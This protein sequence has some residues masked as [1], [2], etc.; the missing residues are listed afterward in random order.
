MEGSTF[1]TD[2][3]DITFEE[4]CQ[5]ISSEIDNNSMDSNPRENVPPR[6]TMSK[7][8][9]L[10][11]QF[12]QPD[13]GQTE[14][15]I[16]CFDEYRKAAMKAIK[17]HLN[18]FSKKQKNYEILD[19]SI[20]KVCTR[21]S[22]L[23]LRALPIWDY[24][25][26]LKRATTDEVRNHL[27]QQKHKTDQIDKNRIFQKRWLTN[28]PRLLP[29]EAAVM[30]ILPCLI[31]CYTITVPENR[32]DPF[33]TNVQN[34]CTGWCNIFV[35][36]LD[37]PFQTNMPDPSSR[38]KSIRSLCDRFLTIDRRKN[39]PR[40]GRGS[41]KN[42]RDIQHRYASFWE[43]YRRFAAFCLA[44]KDEPD[45]NITLS[46]AL[47]WDIQKRN[48]SGENFVLNHNTLSQTGTINDVSS[49]YTKEDIVADTG[50][51]KILKLFDGEDDPDR[52]T[53]HEIAYYLNLAD[54]EDARSKEYNAILKEIDLYEC[55]D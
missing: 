28:I 53:L 6:G 47:F 39:T 2:C 33:D 36:L 31:T 51:D 35:E 12:D 22:D 4:L 34:A 5:L 26:L 23:L 8:L 27:L 29:H 45:V 11:Q 7:L 10:L 14:Q 54:I 37:T 16:I 48:M 52:L 15:D 25:T 41:D 18:A 38:A 24:D 40:K 44:C 46:T 50:R 32:L 13:R 20:Q 19:S 43:Y 3:E 21:G 1:K 49:R 30:R 9:G 55:I 17:D 42:I